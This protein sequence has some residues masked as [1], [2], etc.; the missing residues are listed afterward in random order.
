MNERRLMALKEDWL[1]G[2]AAVALALASIVRPLRCRAIRANRPFS[3]LIGLLIWIAFIASLLGATAELLVDQW[4]SMV[5]FVGGLAFLLFPGYRP[6]RA[7]FQ[8]SVN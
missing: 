6:M 4:W 5:L 7:A 8:S 1:A 3:V 2:N